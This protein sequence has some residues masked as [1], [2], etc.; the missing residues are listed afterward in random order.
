MS[1]IEYFQDDADE[2]RF[3]IKA[4]N[5]LVVAQSEG[6]KEK[7]S[8]EK[9]VAAVIKALV[10]NQ[11]DTPPAILF[12]RSYAPRLHEWQ[13]GVPAHETARD[14]VTLADII[15]AAIEDG[16]TILPPSSEASV[17]AD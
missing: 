5:G 6:Y 15:T 9:G 16:W 8:A 1:N 11:Y 10:T 12:S 4:R 7:R 14:Q 3:R 13:A 17:D 2:W